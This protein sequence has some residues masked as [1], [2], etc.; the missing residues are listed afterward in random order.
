MI[1]LDTHAWTRWLHPELGPILTPQV[2]RWI[3]ES[4]ETLAVSVISCLEIAQLVKKGRLTLPV[5]LPRWFELALDTAGITAIPLS[6]AL[7]HASVGLPE[8]HKDPAD[9]IIIATTQYY[10]AWLVTRDENIQKYPN[11][12]A[13]WNSPPEQHQKCLS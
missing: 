13:F 5:S 3:E 7:L 9:R 1:L 4:D 6:P 11:V 10:D 2:R 12:R 8:I